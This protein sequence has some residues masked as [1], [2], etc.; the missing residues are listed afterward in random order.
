MQCKLCNQF[1]K[2]SHRAHLKSHLEEIHQIDEQ[3]YVI[4]TEFNGIDP[5]CACKLCDERPSFD[6]GKFKQYAL[7]HHLFDVRKQLWIEKFGIP[8]CQNNGCLNDVIFFR[9][10]PRKFCSKQCNGKNIG[11]SLEKTQEK[12]RET[13]RERY[14]VENVAQT[15]H[16]K[17][18][19]AE[20][21]LNH[22]RKSWRHSDETKNLISQKSKER[23][24]KPE[25]KNRVSDAISKS[26]L[27]Q[28]HHE[29][30]SRKMKIQLSDVFFLEKIW[31]GQKNK[32]SK[33]HIKF[34]NELNLEALGFISEQRIERFRVDELHFEKKIVVEINGDYTHANPR[35][36]GP[37]FVVKLRGQQYTAKEKWQSDRN[38]KQR[39]EELGFYVITIWESDN[40]ET[41]R[42]ELALLIDHEN[43]S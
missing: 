43:F 28:E 25:Y 19:T 12:I 10:E 34:R 27:T 3:Q 5:K 40:L 36:Y 38:R 13:V 29:K 2:N 33:L 14:G 6:R 7:N 1:L 21:F 39:L 8:K 4:R 24:A 26:L 20:H 42:Q 30:R 31:D 9:G 32:N 18:K 11:F 16:V 35:F 23:W 41:K 17:M 37:D 15:E 22:P